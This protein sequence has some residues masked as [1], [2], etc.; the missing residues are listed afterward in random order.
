MMQLRDVLRE[1]MQRLQAAGSDSLSSDSTDQAEARNHP[2]PESPS[3]Q[4][5]LVRTTAQ[6]WSG[7]GRGG[8][9]GT[10]LFMTM[11]YLKVGAACACGACVHRVQAVALVSPGRH[12]T[13]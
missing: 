9:K 4:V 11:R 10:Y 12:T 1:A 3:A 5:A 7:R 13:S 2:R 6:A 8:T